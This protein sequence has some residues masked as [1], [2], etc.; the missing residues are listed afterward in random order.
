MNAKQAKYRIQELSRLI[1][2]Y[3]RAYY[4]NH[5]SIVSDAVYDALFKELIALE[6]S[7]PK[8]KSPTSPTQRLTV[9]A[10]SF[11][12]FKHQEPMLSIETVL[13]VEKD[14]VEV[15]KKKTE[16]EL[17]RLGLLPPWEEVNIIPELKFDGL[18]LNL[19]YVYGELV[20]AGTRGDGLEGDDVILNAR[21]IKT[22]PLRLLTEAPAVLEVRG[23]VI[24]PHA[25][26]KALNVR[27]VASG[28]EPYKNPRNAASGLLRQL[29]PEVTMNSKLRFIAYGVG[30]WSDNGAKTQ[31]EVLTRLRGMGFDIFYTEDMMPQITPTSSLDALK[32]FKEII[33]EKRNLLPFD[34]DGVVYKLNSF[35]FQ[36]ALGITGRCPNWAIAH[37]FPAE[38]AITTVES[39]TLQVGRLG[40]ITPVAN[41]KPVFV[42]GVTISNVTLHNQDE[43]DMKDIRIGDAV[44]VRRAGDVI[45]EIVSIVSGLRSKGSLPYKIAEHIT[46]CPC[47]GSPIE[48]EEGKAAYRCTG[49]FSCSAQQAQL[50]EHYCSKR[51]MAIDG[52]GE[53]TAER[54]VTSKLA[55]RVDQLY[56]LT[57]PMLVSQVGMTWVSSSKLLESIHAKTT[58]PLQK[59][60][61]GLGIPSVGEGTSQRLAKH[62]GSIQRLL[63]LSSEE[64]LSELIRIDDIGLKT[65]SS[66]GQYLDQGGR[67]IINN[68]LK[69]VH[70]VEYVSSG[71]LRDRTFVITGSF[72]TN[73][74]EVIKQQITSAGG[75]VSGKVT[76]K[77]DYL[78]VGEN[79]GSKLKDAQ[80][81]KVTTITLEELQQLLKKGKT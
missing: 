24:L 38:E 76:P 40:T 39:I 56:T 10:T 27:S 13:H 45:P 6:A 81:L 15:F 47:C 65:A 55:V 33:Q 31:Y 77:T 1:C 62:F 11:K 58:P 8:H 64:L 48:R 57:A 44:I 7:Y 66:I 41:V 49:G 80:A 28:G 26:F 52:V 25:A 20:G 60:L 14:A 23:E 22:I 69:Y 70:P 29:D 5:T 53:V 30:Y 36:E 50:I 51:A 2:E 74:R 21:A 75:K 46:S 67:A 16:T 68:L 34:I 32:G 78:V 12:I 59:F 42:S 61:Y 18:A 71:A 37:K 35:K 17:E 63:A 9:K 3:D 73:S 43:I 4:I 19:R 54:L 79:A 72:G